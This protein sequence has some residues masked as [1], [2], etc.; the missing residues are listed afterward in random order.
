V[1]VFRNQGG[2]M[3]TAP[4]SYATGGDF[5]A[6][7]VGVAVGDIN[8][9]GRPDILVAYFSG[10]VY[11]LAG[12]ANGGVGPATH[13]TLPLSPASVAL[14][15]VTGDGKLDMIAGGNAGAIDAE[16]AVLANTGTGTFSNP[17]LYSVADF[18]GLTV[19]DLDADGD[20]DIVLTSLSDVSV[21]PNAGDG[22]FGPE[23][24][25]EVGGAHEVVVAD[26]DGDGKRDLALYSTGLFT[27]LG[28][29]DATFV[30]GLPSP[31]WMPDVVTDVNHDGL[32]DLI[33]GTGDPTVQEVMLS[34]GDGTFRLA[35]GFDRPVGSPTTV[36]D[37]DGD[38]NLDVLLTAS[39]GIGIPGQLIVMRGRG[40]GTFAPKETYSASA[41]GTLS[42]AVGDVNNDCM[43]D[44]VLANSG[45][46]EYDKYGNVIAH[47]EGSTVLLLN[48]GDGTFGPPQPFAGTSHSVRLGDV[49]SDGRADAFVSMAE[50]QTLELL[51]D[52]S[53]GFISAATLDR[54][55]GALLD[56]NNDGH[57]DLIQLNA[58]ELGHGDGTFDPPIEPDTP[59]PGSWGDIDG[60][61]NIDGTAFR[62]FLG[63][64]DGTF[65]RR[66]YE[67]NLGGIG[68][69]DGDGYLDSVSD[70]VL[71]QHCW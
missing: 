18:E 33:G 13:Y 43:S 57:L 12:R 47:E 50:G 62:L 35:G 66:E 63:R 22:T 20:E 17:V 46:T 11:M 69:L 8:S 45:A 53:G 21:L 42:L 2:A 52:G 29:G 71:L 36:A 51:A 6:Y 59:Y 24:L 25:H 44:V 60:D 39:G 68:D 10:D 15:D 70:R 32:A 19:A 26:V 37:I 27:L 56:V 38:N 23:Q 34:N 5:Y 9:D 30:E 61:G 65:T 3:F 1:Q 48:N 58:T 64:G 54:D 40:D 49:N 41:P 28:H 4:S 31:L 67:M 16:V 7:P 55:L 14:T